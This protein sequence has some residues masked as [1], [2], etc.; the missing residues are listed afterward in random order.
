M[1]SIGL[2]ISKATVSVHISLGSL[3]LEIENSPNSKN[4][5]KKMLIKWFLYMSYKI[6]AKMLSLSI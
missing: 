3:D 5:I 1:Y 2:D 6:D 4:S